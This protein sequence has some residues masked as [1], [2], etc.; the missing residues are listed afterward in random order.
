[1]R[2]ISKTVSEGAPRT[3]E[4]HSVK[5]QLIRPDSNRFGDESVSDIWI[6]NIVRGLFLKFSYFRHFS[7]D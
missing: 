2:G 4:E 7:E 3:K 1:M 5:Y 6:I